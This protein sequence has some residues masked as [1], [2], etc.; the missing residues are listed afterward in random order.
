MSTVAVPKRG[1]QTLTVE[2]S[3]CGEG[4]QRFVAV[5]EPLLQRDEREYIVDCTSISEIDSAGLSALTWLERQC[6]ERLGSVK[7]CG[8]NPELTTILTM[9]R[10]A[11]RFECY[12]T[13]D[14]AL[15]STG[16]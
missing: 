5:V 8:L 16:H 14:E 11:D 3:L 4:V 2:G 1:V 10:L 12:A 13:M 9:T 15:E 7:L 6:S